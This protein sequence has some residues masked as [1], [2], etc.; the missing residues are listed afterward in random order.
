MHR[1]TNHTPV[2]RFCRQC[3]CRGD[4]RVGAMEV[5]QANM[6]DTRLIRSTRSNQAPTQRVV[7]LQVVSMQTLHSTTFLMLVFR[8]VTPS[9]TADAAGHRRDSGSSTLRRHKPLKP[10]HGY[11]C[12]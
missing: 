9:F 2:S 3:L 12:Q 8:A 10:G 7:T 1:H 11:G 6:D 5:P 4:S